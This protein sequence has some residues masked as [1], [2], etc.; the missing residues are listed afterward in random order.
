MAYLMT[1]EAAFADCGWLYL[2]TVT[3]A[4]VLPVR[5]FSRRW[6]AFVRRW[7]R[8]V[9][10]GM[11]RVYELHPDGHGL[12]CHMLTAHRVDVALVRRI[13][14]RVGL[15]RIHVRRVPGKDEAWRYL[16]K[17]LTKQ[18]RPE[19]LRG[20]RLWQA[21]GLDDEVRSRVADI[22]VRSVRA[23]VLRW[24]MRQDWQVVSR[25]MREAADGS[26]NLAVVAVGQRREYDLG[27]IQRWEV[28]RIVGAWIT[29][30]FQAVVELDSMG[31]FGQRE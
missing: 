26:I 2:W 13:A 7:R 15:G 29:R 4:E 6:S 22:E 3:A 30:N 1:A 24:A 21:V 27:R 23:R 31:I 19:A 11:L 12:H 10:V 8:E 16:A 5:V 9:C 17:Y 25:M 28:L 14:G 18:D 20:M